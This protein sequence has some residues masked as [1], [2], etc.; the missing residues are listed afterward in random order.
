MQKYWIEGLFVTSKGLKK[1]QKSGKIAST[2]IEPFA[3]TFWAINPEEAIALATEALEGGQWTDGPRLGKT[4][5]EQRM[6]ALGAPELPGFSAP[7]K[8]IAKK[9]LKRK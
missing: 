1:A 6:R 3:R 2:D 8:A 9:K 4:T 5:E 7:P